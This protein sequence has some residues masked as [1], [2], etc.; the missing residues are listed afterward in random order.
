M[1]LPGGD[2]P[3]DGFDAL[4][5]ATRAH[6]PFLAPDL[7]RRLLRAYGT[8]IELLLAG[9][10]DLGRDFGADLSE[11]EI[12]YLI[13]HEFARCADDIVWRRSKR[14]LRLTQDQIADIDRFVK[15]QL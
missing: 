10:G 3:I 5:A 7:A 9:R 12:R 2:F 1:A 6:Y 13:A 4:L 8:K 14:G 11:A 15:D